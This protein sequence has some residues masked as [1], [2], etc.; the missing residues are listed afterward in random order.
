MTR[1][2]RAIV[3]LL[4]LL[5]WLFFR[6]VAVTGLHHVPT[7]GGGILISWHPNGLVDPG[8]MLA[9]FP[10]AVAFGARHGLF[11]WPLLGALMRAIGTV[12][13]YRAADATGDPAERRRANRRS[14]DALARAV[15]EGSFAALFPEGRSH[16]APHPLELKQGAARLYYRAR[17]LLPAG[18]PPPVIIPV[19]LHYDAKQLYGSNALVAFHPP[20]ALDAELNVTPADEEPEPAGRERT[21]ELTRRFEDALEEASQATE[22]WELHH[23]ILRTGGLYNAERARREGRAAS[24]SPVVERYAVF[25][26]VRAGYRALTERDPAA[27]ERLRRRMVEYDADLSNLGLEDHE[28]DAAPRLVDRWLPALLAVQVAVSYL[29]LPPLLLLGLLFNGPAALLQHLAVR[30]GAR[31]DKD[32]A[33]IKLLTGVVLYPLSWTV[34]GLLVAWGQL[35][36]SAAYPS[37]PEAP[38]L[39][40]V[41]T[42]LLAAFGGAVALTYRKVVL[43]SWRSMRV[44]L[45]RRRRRA[46]IRRLLAERAA[47]YD[48][49]VALADGLEQELELPGQVTA[50]GRVLPDDVAE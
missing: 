25:A 44:R 36:P 12:P 5:T 45:T 40:G 21:A 31:A 27:L 20:L 32:T 19:G 33:T 17:Q 34:A 39:A 28:L 9:R 30:V 35:G 47:L 26:R 3:A 14:L 8:L 38:V 15:A 37:L 24:R 4:K 13:I 22:S 7:T 16:D 23:L 18:A 1:T 11:R 46:T 10:R 6:R 50:D 2:Y 48:E 42:G 41:V 49:V 29:L 43:H